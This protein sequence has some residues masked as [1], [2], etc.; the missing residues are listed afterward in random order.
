[1]NWIRYS[2]LW[3]TFILNPFHWKFYFNTST[4]ILAGPNQQQYQLQLAFVSIRLVVDN[5][6]W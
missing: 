6:D 2:G 4:D 5:G 3:I 1:M